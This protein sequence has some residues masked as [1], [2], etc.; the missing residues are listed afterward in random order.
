M[1]HPDF[2]RM[3]IGR[4]LYDARKGLARMLNLKSIIIWWEDSK[5]L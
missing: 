2:R 5:I 3:K 4:R 1:V